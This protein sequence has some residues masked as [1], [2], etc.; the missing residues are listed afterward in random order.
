MSGEDGVGVAWDGQGLPGPGDLGDRKVTLK[1]EEVEQT[2][3]I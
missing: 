3:L 1:E 2:R